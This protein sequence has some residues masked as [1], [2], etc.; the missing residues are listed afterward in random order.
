MCFAFCQHIGNIKFV[1]DAREAVSFTDASQVCSSLLTITRLV[2]FVLSFHLCFD[3]IV[4]LLSIIHSFISFIY[5]GSSHFNKQTQ[6]EFVASLLR[7]D[8]VQLG[9]ALTHRHIVSGGEEMD[10]NNNEVQATVVR[11]ALSKVFSCNV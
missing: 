8:A 7:V 2:I 11:D 5:F 1:E 9:R 6:V 4:V 10:V 3:E